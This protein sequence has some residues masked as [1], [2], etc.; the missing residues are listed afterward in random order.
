MK[1]RIYL[2]TSIISALHDER[3]PERLDQTRAFWSRLG[4][5]D[6]TTS[7]LTPGEIFDTPNEDRRRLM[8]A[9][10]S[11]IPIRPLTDG[12]R[13]LAAQYLRAGAFAPT[14]ETDA[15]HV[16]AAVIA[17]NDVLL[18]WNFKHLVNRRRRAMVNAISVAI[19]APT[20]E[21]ISPPEL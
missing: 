2:D 6:A 20:I 1:L 5:Y 11:S 17:R 12:A 15:L 21:I 4:D 8:L 7:D 9:S 19:G 18:S 13:E 10:L 3:T 16:A 14:Q